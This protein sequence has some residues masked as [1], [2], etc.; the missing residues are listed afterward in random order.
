MPDPINQVPGH[1]DFAQ[2]HAQ[3]AMTALFAGN[4]EQHDQALTETRQS[5]AWALSALTAHTELLEDSGP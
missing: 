3:T 1:L 4:R 5:L 2:W